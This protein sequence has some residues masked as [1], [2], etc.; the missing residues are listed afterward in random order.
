MFPFITIFGKTVGLYQ[1]TL[2]LGIFSMGVY[3]CRL[4]TK[5]GHDDSDGINFLLL[6]SIGVFA[7]G[8]ILYSIVNYRIFLHVIKN[9]GSI[10]SFGVFLDAVSLIW[11]GNIFYGGLLGGILAAVIILKKRPQYGYLLDYIAPAIPL[12]HFFGRIGCFFS[13]CCFGVESSLGCTFHN[14]IV[15]QANGINRF[16]VQLLEAFVNLMLFFA[17]DFLRRKNF[18]SQNLIFFYLLFYSVARFFIE[19]LRGDSYRGYFLFLSTSQIISILI[20]CAVIPRIY[21]LIR[22]NPR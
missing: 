21:G 4:C 17:L 5:N 12:F 14:S 6:A 20:F 3:V 16:P 8:H 10:D 19:F 11:G 9:I 1:I 22:R 2:L 13:G 7:G 18:F 15:E